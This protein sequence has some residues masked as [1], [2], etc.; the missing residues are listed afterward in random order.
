[1]EHNQSTLAKW[2]LH[3]NEELRC[4][5]KYAGVIKYNTGLYYMLDIASLYYACSWNHSAGM[6]MNITRE[7]YIYRE[8]EWPA[9]SP[10]N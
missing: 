6:H 4:S 5:S 8:R 3:V 1:M 7:V 9:I 10:Y 2:R